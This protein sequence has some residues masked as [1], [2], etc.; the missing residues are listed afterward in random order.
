MQKLFLLIAALSGSIG[1]ILGA[2]GSH[3]LKNKINYWE[4]NSYETGIRYQFI[5]VF[6]L[7]AVAILMD[8]IDSNEK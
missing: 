2:I 1:V 7:I 4:L 6:A 8:K 3:L 5:H